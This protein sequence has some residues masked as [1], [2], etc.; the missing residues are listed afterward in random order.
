V[1]RGITRA[2]AKGVLQ[3]EAN[4]R[5]G[6]LAGVLA[7]IA[8]AATEQADDRMWRTL[9]G[10][11]SV[12]RG[13]VPEGEHR[14]VLDGRDT[15]ATI[16][17]S[18][19]YALVPLQIQG[20]AVSVG[21]VSTFGQLVAAA[22]TQA[23]PGLSSVPSGNSGPA[24]AAAAPKPAAKPAVRKP[25]ATPA[26]GTSAPTSATPAAGASAPAKKP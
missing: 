12:A 6:P 22:P 10:L 7:T 11:V 23:A 18:G 21:E 26:G 8:S 1:V 3:N 2:I 15:G 25:A 13:Y 24:G 9:P 5:G 17:V 20:G 19:Q 14:L 4:K 16:K